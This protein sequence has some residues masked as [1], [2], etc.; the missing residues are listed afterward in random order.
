MPKDFKKYLI[1]SG[2]VIL[3]LI[4]YSLFIYKS[5]V[6]TF[7]QR[8]EK[9]KNVLPPEIRKEFEAANYEKTTQL[10]EK[11]YQKNEAF[12]KALDQVKDDEAIN[13]FTIREVVEFYRD[14]FVNHKDEKFR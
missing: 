13:L 2:L 11:E 4:F 9:F 14:Y 5:P 1:I 6:P 12:K 7:S 8:L 3:G 10:M